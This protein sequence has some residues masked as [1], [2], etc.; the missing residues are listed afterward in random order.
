MKLRNLFAVAVLSLVAASC[1]DDD[2]VV[3]NGAE[4]A[5]SYEGE[6][7]QVVMG[8]ESKSES[9]L[10]LKVQ[11][12][13]R[14][15]I[16]FSAAGEG[17]MATPEIQLENLAFVANDKGECTFS[18]SKTDTIRVFNAELRKEYLYTNMNGTVKDQKLNLTYDCKL[19]KMPFWMNATFNGTKK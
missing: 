10:S 5:G 6:M 12:D 3:N 9:T 18:I 11:K 13:N 2:E 8:S 17:S 14:L 1:S 4:F 19:G 15:T 7:V 16:V